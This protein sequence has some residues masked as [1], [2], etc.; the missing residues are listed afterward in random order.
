MNLI[1]KQCWHISKS[2]RREHHHRDPVFGSTSCRVN[3]RI[4]KIAILHYWLVGMRGG[5]KVLESLC[6]LFPEA[7]IF[8]HVHDP[9]QISATINRHNIITSFIQRLPRAA[10]FYKKYL[11]LMPFAVEA[12]D[13]QSYDLIISSEAGPIKGVITRPD[14]LNICYCHSPMRYVW[15]QYHDYRR[16]AGRMTRLAMSLFAT[17]LRIWDSVSA[18]RV[19]HFIANSNFVA[20]RIKKYYGRD[21]VVI[22]PPVDAAKFHIAEAQEDYFICF[23]QMI[24]YKR[25]DLAIEAFNQNGRRLVV[26]GRGE[27]EAALRKIAGRNISFLGPQSDAAVAA[28]L[29]GCQALIFPGVE[30]FG[31]VPLEAMASGRPVIAYAA[32]GALETM[33]D[34][35]TGVLFHDQSVAGLNQ[36]VTRYDNL[37]ASFEP[38]AIRAHAMSFDKPVFQKK[39]MDFV[40]R[41]LAAPG[42]A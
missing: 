28:L 37:A 23:G 21:S 1:L 10:K 16:S 4:L 24:F 31:I 22:H 6:E 40:M 36:A 42:P 32:G 35:V 7:D 34:G 9:A 26:I 3:D 41:H 30:D 19:D 25:F 18:T 11:L 17:R 38:T 5:E 8:T 15:D 39:I 33:I 29:A 13:L 12:L 14:A 27:Q 20:K 2:S